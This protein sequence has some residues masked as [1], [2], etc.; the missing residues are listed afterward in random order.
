MQ[1]S[2][3]NYH[4]Y[5]MIDKL[6]D[7]QTLESER[8]GKP[9]HDEMLFIVVHQVYEL[10]FKLILAE[11]QS[12]LDIFAQDHIDERLMDRIVGRLQRVVDPFRPI[13][14]AD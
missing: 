9:A 13:V 12:V 1:S 6:L 4:D 8:L 11:V 10:W 5:L 14:Q 7:C 2:K 3:M